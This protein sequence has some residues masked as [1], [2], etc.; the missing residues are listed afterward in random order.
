MSNPYIGEIRMVGFNYAPAGW[1]LCNGVSLAISQNQALYSLIGT[2]YGGDGVSV[3]A[4]PNLLSRVPVSMGQGPGLSNYV[5]GQVGGSETVTLTSGQLPSHTHTVGCT[6]GSSNSQTPQNNFWGTWGDAQYSDQPANTTM[7]ANAVAQ[8]PWGSRP[9]D[10]LMPF[11]AIN[12]II[13]LVGI[14]PSRN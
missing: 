8:P 9:H 13:A 4:L 12:F 11:Q 5:L 10:N 3:F 2:T 6:S 14:Y 7:N 1:A